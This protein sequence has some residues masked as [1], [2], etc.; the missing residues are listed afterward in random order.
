MLENIKMCLPT[1]S[2]WDRF[3][4]VAHGNNSVMHWRSVF[5]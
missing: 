2:E 1:S 3:V 5:S 4:D